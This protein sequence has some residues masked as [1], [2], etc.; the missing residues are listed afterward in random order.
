[1]AAA[2]RATVDGENDGRPALKTV[3]NCFTVHPE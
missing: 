1:M 3:R 2:K